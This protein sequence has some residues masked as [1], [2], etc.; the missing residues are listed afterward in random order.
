METLAVGGVMRALIP[1]L[2]GTPSGV[3]D[4][5][6]LALPVQRAFVTINT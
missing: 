2:R 3:C 4:Y 5:L 6:D 1:A